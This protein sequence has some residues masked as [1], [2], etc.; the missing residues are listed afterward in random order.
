MV[1]KDLPTWVIHLIIISLIVMG[2]I[3]IKK[4]RIV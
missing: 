4:R 3:K 2:Y 1:V